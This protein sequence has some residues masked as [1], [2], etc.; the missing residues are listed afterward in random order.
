MQAPKPVTAVEEIDYISI[1]L[2]Q[3]LQLDQRKVNRD[4]LLVLLTSSPV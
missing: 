1:F 2:G 4:H 3:G